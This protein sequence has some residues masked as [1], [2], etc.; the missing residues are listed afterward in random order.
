MSVRDSL[1]TFSPPGVVDSDPVET[2]E[3]LDAVVRASGHERALALLRLLEEQ[4][5]RRSIV[6]NVPPFSA[7][8]N[9]V[10]VEDEGA[11]PGDLAMEE[12]I[13]SIVRWNALAMVVRANV[14]YGE[15]GGHIGSYAS[16]AEC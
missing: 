12:R 14:A 15:L 1:P 9:T 16:A 5:S 13:T 7:Y 6:A 3:W 10:P 11:Y 8:R 4:A 2:G